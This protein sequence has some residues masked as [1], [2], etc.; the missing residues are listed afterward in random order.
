MLPSTGLPLVSTY[1]WYQKNN[2]TQQQTALTIIV[3]ETKQLDDDGGRFQ[4]PEDWACEIEGGLDWIRD[5][6]ESP[7]EEDETPLFEKTMQVPMTQRSP[8]ERAPDLGGR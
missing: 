7:S 5:V 8:E 2:R 4:S 6:G 1:I 3:T